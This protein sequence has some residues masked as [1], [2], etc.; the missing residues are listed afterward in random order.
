MKGSF[1]ILF[2]EKRKIS[3]EGKKDGWLL[4]QKA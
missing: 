3:Y 4:G 1:L 2:L